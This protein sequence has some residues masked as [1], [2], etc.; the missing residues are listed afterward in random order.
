[1]KS[2]KFISKDEFRYN[3]I[4]YFVLLGL[5][6]VFG[7]FFVNSALL[8]ME[9]TRNFSAGDK[10]LN[11]I[12]SMGI[13][14]FFGFI[15]FKFGNSFLRK[16]YA[17]IYLFLILI[18]FLT[19]VLFY[20]EIAEVHRWIYIGPFQ[21]QPSE[22][23]KLLLPAI[24]ASYY[25]RARE[26][27]N[28]FL[29]VIFPFII[30]AVPIFLIYIEPDLSTSV[31]VAVIFFFSVFISVKNPK[32]IITF[33]IICMIIVIA[34]FAFKDLLLKDYQVDRLNKTDNYQMNQSLKAIE[35]GGILGTS[36]FGG[37]LKYGVPESYSDFIMAVIG[38]EWGKLGIFMVISIF[39]F[40]AVQLVKMA[41]FTNDYITFAYSSLTAVWIFI[42]VTV[43]ALVGLG[44]NFVPVTG[45]TLPLMSYGNSSLIITLTSL[46]LS[47]GL[48]YNQ[49]KIIFTE[50]SDEK[51]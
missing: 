40:L 25:Y 26:K 5:A 13:G 22:L 7:I 35:N 23:A 19:Y 28:F 3:F 18:G 36:P 48:I 21:F 47:L 33:L 8:A 44:V 43:N 49:Y 27:N 51:N 4:F 42:Q 32:Y 41:Y 11:H 39:L 15:A 45:V 38:E 34:L 1:M 12:I 6:L 9:N 17:F 29:N 37:E 16:K 30:C 46:F 20:R 2:E 24:M 10:F 31:I 14:F 50:D